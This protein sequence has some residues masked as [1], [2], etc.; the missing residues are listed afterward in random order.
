MTGILIIS[1][2]TLAI[3]LKETV[4]AVVGDREN[5]SALCITKEERLEDFT[6]RLKAEAER[7]K[8]AGGLLI[9]ADMFG[10]TPCNA[11]VALFGSDEDVEII[12]GF[13]MPLVIEAVMKSEM[14]AAEIT[15]MLM[16]KK[17]KTII[18]VKS[19]MKKRV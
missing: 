17:E 8:K 4:A 7:L 1:H 11:S 18:D 16:A 15:S 14:K 12:T 3:S 13:N 2:H 5:V 6:E 19:M 9:F 10:G